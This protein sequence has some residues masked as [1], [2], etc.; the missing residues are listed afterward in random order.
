MNGHKPIRLLFVGM[1]AS[2][3]ACA[4]YVP[5]APAPPEAFSRDLPASYDRTW[6][7]VTYV[8]GASFFKIKA[9]EKASGLM[10]LDFDLKDVVPYVDCGSA[11]NSTT[12]QTSPALLALGFSAVSLEGTANINIRSEG[13]RRTAIQFNSQYTLSGYKPDGYGNLVR[14]A[15]WQFNSGSSDTQNIGVM[16]VCRPS[17]KIERD[18]LNEVSAR[19]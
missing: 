6:S 8:A 17:Y 19:L 15:Q 11:V 16:V 9:F 14:V 1:L 13:R 5:P 7:A 3:A 18:F 4:T 10:T 12:H 2:V